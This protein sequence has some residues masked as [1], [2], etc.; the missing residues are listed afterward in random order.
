[1]Y[2]QIRKAGKY[3]YIY[4]VEAYRKSNGKIAHRTIDKIGRYDKLKELN[5]NF[6]EELKASVKEQSESIKVNIQHNA[7][8][9][10]IKHNKTSNI[11]SP[12]FYCVYY[13]SKRKTFV[14]QE[15][16]ICSFW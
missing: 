13:I 10:F 1:M 16:I 8:E 14:R 6:L 4:V 9:N 11:F 12:A 7:V 2:V 5:P 3:E 15:P